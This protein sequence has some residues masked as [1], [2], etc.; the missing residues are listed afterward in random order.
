MHSFFFKIL[1][2][3]LRP[4]PPY[5]TS[6][7]ATKGESSSSLADALEGEEPTPGGEGDEQQKETFSVTVPSMVTV[8]PMDKLLLA[9]RAELER[10]DMY[11]KQLYSVLFSSTKAQPTASRPLCREA[12][13]ETA[14]RQA[15]GVKGNDRTPGA[16]IDVVMGGG[17]VI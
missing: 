11:N 5:R 10:T 8:P 7:H 12:R 14:T 1:D 17:L 6:R 2:G 15:S 9:N 4:E 3:Q 16:A 13:L